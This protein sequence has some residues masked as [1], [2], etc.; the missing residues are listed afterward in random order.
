MSAPTLPVAEVFGPTFQG[1][2]P[3]AGRLASFVRLGGCNLTCRGC[4]TPYTWDASRFNLRDE[5]TP[6]TARDILAKLPGVTRLVV[7][8]GGEPTMY[9]NH[10]ALQDLLLELWR[11]GCEVE[12]ETNGTRVPGPMAQ[13]H[14]RW[15]VSP[16]LD[17]PMSV[18]P[19]AKRLVPEALAV[20]AEL[21]QDGRAAWK[22]VVR[23]AADVHTAME[24]VE[25]YRVPARAVWIMPE[26]TTPQGTLTVARDVA[27]T[28]LTYG[29]NMTLRQHVLLW[30]TTE[31]GR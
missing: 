30:P 10:T 21:A 14:V 1:E 6:M 2:G 19:A 11:Q 23:R 20:Y 7:I 26:G 13:D 5:L 15:N 22:L 28:A 29:V 25:Q 12:V 24:L 16:K 18:D 27:D 17:G 8:T 3:S 9:R 31:R 4:D